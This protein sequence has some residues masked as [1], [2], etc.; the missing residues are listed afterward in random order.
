MPNEVMINEVVFPWLKVLENPKLYHDN[1]VELKALGVFSR[2][3][4][5][6]SAFKFI[7]KGKYASEFP[8]RFRAGQIVRVRACAEA[9]RAKVY[10]KLGRP[11]KY[12]DGTFRYTTK[13]R[14]HIIKIKHGQGWEV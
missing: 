3:E 7:Y 6:H 13:V 4:K 2:K 14:F 11:I 12:P 9:Y 1:V 10:G 8:N 5:Y